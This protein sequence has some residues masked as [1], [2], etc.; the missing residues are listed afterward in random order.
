LRRHGNGEDDA[1]GTSSPDRLD[2]RAGRGPGCQPVVHQDDDAAVG[3]DRA[4]VSTIALNAPRQLCPLARSRRLELIRQDAQFFDQGVVEDADT[5]FRDRADPEFG[6]PGASDLSHDDDVQD[7]SET[8]GDDSGDKHAA[9]RQP[10]HERLQ[11]RVPGQAA[12]ELAAR[13]ASILEHSSRAP[14]TDPRSGSACRLHR[15]KSIEG[16][17]T[18]SRSSHSALPLAGGT[19]QHGC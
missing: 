19:W 3:G 13:I 12:G 6:L 16:W 5:T 17:T 4:S 7:G 1:T 9:A 15:G 11:R 10:D 14:S 18:S 8:V 2:R